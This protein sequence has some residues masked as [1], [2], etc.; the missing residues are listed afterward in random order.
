MRGGGGE[1]RWEVRW[2][3][4]EVVLGSEME[5]AVVAGGEAVAGGDVGGGEWAEVRCE[6]RRDVCRR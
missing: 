5:G 3:G 6:V 2:W 1:V 4:G